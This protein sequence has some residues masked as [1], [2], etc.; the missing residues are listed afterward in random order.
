MRI[1][2]TFV[3]TKRDFVCL[4]LNNISFKKELGEYEGDTKELINSVDISIVDHTTKTLLSQ[5]DKMSITIPVIIDLYEETFTV[6]TEEK[7]KGES[8]IPNYYQFSDDAAKEIIM[9]NI[10]FDSDNKIKVCGLYC[11]LV[12]IKIDSFEDKLFDITFSFQR[13]NYKELYE[14]NWISV[15]F[16]VGKMNEWIRETL[17]VLVRDTIGCMY[18]QNY[19][20]DK[21]VHYCRA[22]QRIHNEENYFRFI[23]DSID[24][25]HHRPEWCLGILY[26]E[27]M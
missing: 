4:I 17:T 5:F 27:S 6:P 7:R 8:N 16:L 13:D 15:I 19:E 26:R 18:C 11:D 22:R 14:I 25:E 23:P 20:L 2:K 3:L 12:N 10:I 1:N 9:R 24:V 21:G